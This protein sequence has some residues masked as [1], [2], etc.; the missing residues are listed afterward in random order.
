MKFMR[1]AQFKLAV[2]ELFR[3]PLR[4]VP[5]KVFRNFGSPPD[6]RKVAAVLSTGNWLT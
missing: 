1:K 3:Q 4:R 6:V 2:S 5:D